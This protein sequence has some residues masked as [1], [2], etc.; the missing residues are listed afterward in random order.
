MNCYLPEALA[1]L[2]PAMT[3]E[4]L[5]RLQARGEL[6]TGPALWCDEAHR[7]HCTVGGLPAVIPRA[8]GHLDAWQYSPTAPGICRTFASAATPDG[9]PIP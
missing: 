2:T 8:E 5:R 6:V 4:R 7:L 3:P 1:P 9:L